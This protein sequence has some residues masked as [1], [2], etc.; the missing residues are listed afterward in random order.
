MARKIDKIIIH[1]S[2]SPNGRP[3][4]IQDVDAWHQAR[5]FHRSH[6]IGNLDLKAIGYHFIIYIDGTIHAGRDIEE[7]GAHA[8]GFNAN[9]IGIC[10][11]GTDKFTIPQW[12]ELSWQIVQLGGKYPQAQIL[13]HRDLPDV[14]KLCPGFD[15][16]TWLAGTRAGLEGHIF[17]GG[18]SC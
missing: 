2:A 17:E 9:S 12:S 5:G 1:C 14:H 8:T 4:T 7:I 15:V 16:A 11:L 3:Q 13:G 18:E 10:M 6:P